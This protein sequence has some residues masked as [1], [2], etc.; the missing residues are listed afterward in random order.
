M[1][2]ACSPTSIVII[3]NPF[4]QRDP[5]QPELASQFCPITQVLVAFFAQKLAELQAHADCTLDSLLSALGEDSSGADG[6]ENAGATAAR[7]AD[8][9]AA[10]AMEADPWHVPLRGTGETDS[11]VPLQ[12]QGAPWPNAT[13][14]TAWQAPLLEVTALLRRLQQHDVGVAAVAEVVRGDLSASVQALGKDWLEVHV[15][16]PCEQYM[17]RV[18]LHLQQIVLSSLVRRPPMDIAAHPQLPSP[19][20]QAPCLLCWA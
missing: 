17:R 13:V 4:T 9:D 8:P 7:F 5:P 10:D 14:P 2:V 3:S 18:P 16:G 11:A 19:A 1:G 6:A 20:T 12:P 15:L